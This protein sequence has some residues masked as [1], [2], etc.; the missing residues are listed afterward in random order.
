M[1][2]VKRNMSNQLFEAVGANR[3]RPS[4][5]AGTQMD[6][7]MA[8]ILGKTLGELQDYRDLAHDESLKAEQAAR[9][10]A[11]EKKSIRDKIAEMK[12]TIEYKKHLLEK[13]QKR[14]KSSG[15]FQEEVVQI[16]GQSSATSKQ[17]NRTLKDDAKS[18]LDE[19]Y[20]LRDRLLTASTRGASTIPPQTKMKIEE[21]MAEL[22]TKIDRDIESN[23]RVAANLEE[24][25]GHAQRAA[26]NQT[27]R[28]EETKYT[29][30]EIKKESEELDKD[31]ENLITMKFENPALQA[32]TF[33]S[34]R[35]SGHG[36]SDDTATR[37]KDV[38]REKADLKWKIGSLESEVNKLEF[39]KNKLELESQVRNLKDNKG[40]VIDK[41]NRRIDDARYNEQH[42]RDLCDHA[43]DIDIDVGFIQRMDIEGDRRGRI[44]QLQDDVRYKQQSEQQ[45]KEE[46]RAL[47]DKLSAI[48]ELDVDIKSFHQEDN[49]GHLLQDLNIGYNDIIQSVK[50]HL[51]ANASILRKEKEIKEMEAR[52][53]LIDLEALEEEYQRLRI[54]YDR[55]SEILRDLEERYSL[56]H[57]RL[58]RLRA[59]LRELNDLIRSLE[60]RLEQARFEIEDAERKYKLIKVP[61]KIEY[62]VNERVED[63]LIKKKY[64]TTQNKLS[65]RDY[66]REKTKR[67][68][69]RVVG[70]E[71][72]QP[73][74]EELDAI[75]PMGTKV[76]IERLNN[77]GWYRYGTKKFYF[78]K[79]EDGEFYVN[80]EGTRM[81]ID[82]FITLYE[83]E[84][85]K[86]SNKV[87]ARNV[88][89]GNIDDEEADAE[90]GDEQAYR[91]RPAHPN[92]FRR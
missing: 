51:T 7:L 9:D 14:N 10:A 3:I 79:G 20:K 84:E 66:E 28:I 87:V 86:T 1:Q 64:L 42:I 49:Y 24:N 92:Y 43:R 55:D 71:Y 27:M 16:S 44:R 72:Y 56:I 30:T 77:E 62:I 5:S 11:T 29:L 65:E 4:M 85:R 31:I 12:K 26:D 81:T 23:T 15:R 83:A 36:D 47:K 70:T 39:Q 21:R 48:G 54:L 45:T 34:K 2:A 74:R 75:L 52:I 50:D 57:D 68:S 73:T 18:Q 37:L 32:P 78:I 6:P 82:D 91:V 13:A 69:G 76:V 19:A 8:E 33:G 59:R 67:K 88:E 46:I 53:A 38:L 41:L 60:E 25:L 89:H 17:A 35:P 58:I 40:D 61:K 22:E 80:H 90:V 63:V